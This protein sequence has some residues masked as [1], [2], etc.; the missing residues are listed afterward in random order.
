M[1]FHGR[2]SR[3]AAETAMFDKPEEGSF[4]IRYSSKPCCFTVD[5]IKEGKLC[6]F[7]NIEND[8]EGGILVTM[9]NPDEDKRVIKYSNLS[10]FV[11]KNKHLFV[12]PR[13]Y[14]SS[15]FQWLKLQLFLETDANDFNDVL[16]VTKDAATLSNK[17]KKKKKPR[18]NSDKQKQKDKEKD[19]EE[20]DAKA[21][22]KKRN[23]MDMTKTQK[24]SNANPKN[25]SPLSPSSLLVPPSSGRR[26]R[27]IS[28]SNIRSDLKSPS[29]AEPTS[30]TKRKSS[31]D[32]PQQ[33]QPS[34]SIEDPSSSSSSATT[35]SRKRNNSI[36]ARVSQELSKVIQHSQQINR[37]T[38]E[39]R[40]L[41]LGPELPL[42]I[43]KLTH[44]VQ[45]DLSKNILTELPD[46]LGLLFSLRSL[47]I[48]DNHIT[49]LNPEPFLI[50]S[51][52]SNNPRV[53]E[54]NNVG[55]TGVLSMLACSE[56]LLTDL[57]AALFDVSTLS[58]LDV[59]KNGL[60]RLSSKIGRLHNLQ[61]LD[62][63]GNNLP[64][65][66]SAI[67]KLASLEE[68]YAKGNKL[69]RLCRN[70]GSMLSL[71][72]LDVED[73]LLT[74]IPHDLLA[75]IAKVPTFVLL[76]N[77]NKISEEAFH[78]RRKP[79][80]GSPL[81]QSMDIIDI[82]SLRSPKYIQELS[83]ISESPYDSDSDT[84][85]YNSA[86]SS[87]RLTRALSD[88]D[89]NEEYF[90]TGLE[91]PSLW[92]ESSGY[93]VEIS[94]N[95]EG[96]TDLTLCEHLST[97]DY[98]RYFYGKTVHTNIIGTDKVLGPL[99][100][101]IQKDTPGL[102]SASSLAP[103]SSSASSHKTHNLTPTNNSTSNNEDSSV[104]ATHSGSFSGEASPRSTPPIIIAGNSFMD[105]TAL[106]SGVYRALIRTKERDFRVE[107][108][109][110]LVKMRK[111]E[112]YARSQDLLVA[113][114]KMEPEK[115]PHFSLKN[116]WVVRDPE[117]Y[118]EFANTEDILN[119]VNSFKFGVLYATDGQDETAMYNNVGG[120]ADFEKFLRILG[121]KIQ[122]KGWD[123]YSGGLSTTR[124]QQSIYTKFKGHEIMFHVNTLLPWQKKT[125]EFGQQWERK[126]HIGNDIVVIIYYEGKKPIDPSI[127]QSNFNHVFAIVQPQR[128]RSAELYKLHMAYK[129]GV[130]T[131]TLKHPPLPKNGIF[132]ADASFF[133]EYFLTKLINAERCAISAPCFRGPSERARSML[134]E[135]VQEKFPKK[136]EKLAGTPKRVRKLSHRDPADA[137][138]SGHFPAQEELVVRTE[139]TLLYGMD[140]ATMQQML[141]EMR[142]KN[143]LHN[144]EEKS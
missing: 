31:L 17:L 130:H 122:L 116:L 78:P 7:N 32:Q 51:G 142:E 102:D 104:S 111:K 133:R 19:T 67:V 94:G 46:A 20:K 24:V 103:S 75:F 90:V 23:S 27:S 95:G 136:K 44:L 126:R 66:P 40:N 108:P 34:V 91:L 61:F 77:G 18:R 57:P 115:R 47:D 4:M 105:T 55:R 52:N 25:D 107:I 5:Y 62:I 30:P 70:M 100:I 125:D 83:T 68:L 139:N 28:S 99:F 143:I 97:S 11:A 137:I 106:K 13:V 84:E 64:K 74:E 120:S 35:N 63:S 124:D 93:F 43:C 73:N 29:S 6:H 2:L 80:L 134:L 48:S 60:T 12:Y 36:T 59:S 79:S 135:E 110:S 3:S 87:P 72:V 121:D 129:S 45:L 131:N 96:C 69:A 41:S 82:L 114:K 58:Y 65:L 8:P 50:W 112:R 113:L 101:S 16:G 81:S 22:S 140:T 132:K 127:F 56:N 89:Q 92:I 14:H 53:V 118:D 26:T 33:E 88:L 98:R 144:K 10:A 76:K 86:P 37:E 21:K 38:L 1:W 141:A 49:S 119:G 15:N 138:S 109:A 42:D 71:A 85:T 9:G 128:K 123:K 117:I 39:L 54:S